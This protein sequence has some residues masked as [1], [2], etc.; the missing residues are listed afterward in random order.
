MPYDPVRRCNVEQL[1]NTAVTLIFSAGVTETHS[2][3]GTGEAFR[4]ME[5]CFEDAKARGALKEYTWPWQQPVEEAS[6]TD[7]SPE[8]ME[9]S[10]KLRELIDSS[11]PAYQWLTT[12]TFECGKCGKDFQAY[13]GDFEFS[14][15]VCGDCD[16][17]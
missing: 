4:H 11:F 9:A 17:K 10:I 3:T 14:S 2:V 15:P 1:F 16:G 12:V 5:V 8:E 13:Q 7:R 6:E